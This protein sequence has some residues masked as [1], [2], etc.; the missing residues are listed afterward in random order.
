MKTRWLCVKCWSKHYVLCTSDAQA[1]IIGLECPCGARNSR[2]RRIG[3]DIVRNERTITQER[4]LE[5]IL[6]RLR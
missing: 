6:R 3:Y 5:P 1:L 4:Q 2:K